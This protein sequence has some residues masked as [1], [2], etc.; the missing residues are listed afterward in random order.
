MVRGISISTIASELNIS[1]STVK[2]DQAWIRG[3]LREFAAGI[4][5]LGEVGQSL[6]TYQEIEHEALFQASETSSPQ[7]KNGYL[8]TAISARR[9]YMKL[10]MDVGLVEKAATK[11]DMNIDLTKMTTEELL[12]ERAKSVARLREMGLPGPN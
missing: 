10:L 6:A 5:A 4:D 11:L 3:N 8:M 12:Q 1:Q 7:A 9:E 2:S